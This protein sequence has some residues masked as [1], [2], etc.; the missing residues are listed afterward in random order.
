MIYS[1]IKR[2]ANN[3]LVFLI[4]FIVSI[5]ALGYF[6]NQIGID[7]TNPLSPVVYFFENI[8]NNFKYKAVV[9]I[10][11]ALIAIEVIPEH[12]P[13]VNKI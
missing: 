3:I 6:G 2:N 10:L 4:A 5:I 11:I 8:Y 1:F 7:Y 9:A 12:M 13:S